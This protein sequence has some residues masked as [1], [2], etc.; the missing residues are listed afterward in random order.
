MLSLKQGEV[1]Q[2][3]DGVG[4]VDMSFLTT[5]QSVDATAALCDHRDTILIPLGIFSLPNPHFVPPRS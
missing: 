5:D 1:S 3:A 2:A 4:V